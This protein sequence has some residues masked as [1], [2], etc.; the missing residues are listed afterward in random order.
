MG[1]PVLITSDSVNEKYKEAILSG[2]RLEHKMQTLAAAKVPGVLVP[3]IHTPVNDTINL[4]NL[5]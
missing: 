3:K 4:E 5:L 2:R 1:K